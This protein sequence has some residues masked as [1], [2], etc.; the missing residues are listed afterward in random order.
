MCICVWFYYLS[1]LTPVCRILCLRI[2]APLENFMLHT[3][4]SNSFRCATL[5]LFASVFCF[6]CKLYD[7]K[8]LIIIFVV[9]FVE[10]K[11]INADL[12]FICIYLLSLFMLMVDDEAVADVESMV[13][14]VASSF[15]PLSVLAFT[16]SIG[17]CCRLDPLFELFE[18]PRHWATCTNNSACDI[19][20]KLS[21]RS[22][23]NVSIP[24]KSYQYVIQVT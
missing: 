11:E 6:N 10:S 15:V 9:V 5:P 24:K 21:H 18:S 23:F 13:D 16:T 14:C 19:V 7:L 17:Y 20:S 1:T 3:S 22:H 8:Q 4:H 2:L 12:T